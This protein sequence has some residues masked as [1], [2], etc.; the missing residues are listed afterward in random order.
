MEYSCIYEL[1]ALLE[2]KEIPYYARDLFGGKQIIIGDPTTDILCDAVCHQYSKGN[3][4]NLLEIMN[5]MT[6]EERESDLVLGFLTPEEVLKRF[7]Y[8]YNNCT[9]IYKESDK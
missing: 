7:S 6:E 5:G 9:K 8:C 2:K 3:E 1:M 4:K